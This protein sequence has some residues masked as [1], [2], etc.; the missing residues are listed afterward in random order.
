MAA[1]KAAPPRDP[2]EADIEIRALAVIPI[3][4]RVAGENGWEVIDYRICIWERER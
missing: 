3:L 1:R 4:R 2:R